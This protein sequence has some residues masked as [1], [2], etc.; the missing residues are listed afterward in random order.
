[1]EAWKNTEFIENYCKNH[2]VNPSWIPD[3]E[4]PKKVIKDFWNDKWTKIQKEKASMRLWDPVASNN[5]K[6]V[7][8]SYGE[9]K[10][11]YGSDI[12]E[13]CAE[14]NGT[15]D[16][17]LIKEMWASQKPRTKQANNAPR[18]RKTT[19]TKQRFRNPFIGVEKEM[20]SNTEVLKQNSN[21]TM[22]YFF[23]RAH[24][25]TFASAADTL[26]IFGRFYIDK[27]L[28]AASYTIEKLR[29]LF[30]VGSERTIRNW[31]NQL[32]KEGAIVKDTQYDPEKKEYKPTVFV[33]GYID[34]ED[35]Y[36]YLYG[37]DG[38][39]KDEIEKRLGK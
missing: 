31:I 24:E 30:G 4:D 12:A 32:E 16:E 22:L 8:L 29:Q 25:W 7:R 11:K 19:K 3:T 39:V 38:S 5:G 15:Y 26:N 1:M 33:L 23:L 28:L 6:T 2:K 34:D 27:R 36:I 21:K 37:N 13:R 17:K 14:L 18:T 35:Y 10:E 20:L 9:L